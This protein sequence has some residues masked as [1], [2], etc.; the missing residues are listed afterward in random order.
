MNFNKNVLI[1]WL[2]TYGCLGSEVLFISKTSLYI[3]KI[4]LK[5]EVELKASWLEVAADLIVTYLTVNC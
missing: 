3:F 1:K 5:N 2:G 4:L